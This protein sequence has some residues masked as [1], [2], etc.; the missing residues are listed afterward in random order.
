MMRCKILSPCFWYCLLLGIC[1]WV[2]G[3]CAFCFYTLSFKF[4]SPEHSDGIVVL[5]GAGERISPALGLL[6]QHYAGDL[7]ISGVHPSV[8]SHDLIQN[9]SPEL[10]ERVTLGYQAH[11]TRENAQETSEWIKQKGLHSVLLITSFYHMPRSLFEVQRLNPDIQVIPVPTFP[12]AADQGWLHGR[13]A[14]LL[15][16]EYHKFIFIHFQN[17]MEGFF[18]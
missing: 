15:F 5:T 4:Q 9:L 17:W 16:L 10:K 12:K 7:L 8:R 18:S 13:Y 2:I 1:L 11:N 3:F 14:W 6:T